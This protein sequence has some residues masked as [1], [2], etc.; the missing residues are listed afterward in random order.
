MRLW[1]SLAPSEQALVE[2]LRANGP[3]CAKFLA[4]RLAMSQAQTMGILTELAGDGWLQRVHGTFLKKDR[5]RPKHMNHT[6]YALAR[7]A[8][9]ALRRLPCEH[10]LR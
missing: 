6:Y 4:R 9:L 2:D 8:A 1:S 7:S 5:R 3:D 10:L